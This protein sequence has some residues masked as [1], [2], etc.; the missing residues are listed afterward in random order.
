MF[1]E[2]GRIIIRIEER[3]SPQRKILLCNKNNAETIH[4]KLIHLLNNNYCGN[5]VIKLQIETE[6]LSSE[7]IGFKDEIILRIAQWQLTSL[8]QELIRKPII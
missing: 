1:V 8:L 6:V 7:L 3:F 5:P 4:I 2:L